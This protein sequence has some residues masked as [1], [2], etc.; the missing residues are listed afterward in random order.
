MFTLRLSL[1]KEKH[2]FHFQFKVMVKKQIPSIKLQNTWDIILQWKKMINTSH[3]FPG[4]GKRKLWTNFIFFTAPLFRAI[5]DPCPVFHPPLKT[6]H[7]SSILCLCSLQAISRLPHSL[8]EIC[9]FSWCSKPNA[10]R[11]KR[12]SLLCDCDNNNTRP[13]TQCYT[14]M[15]ELSILP[16]LFSPEKIS[17]WNVS[18]DLFQPHYTRREVNGNG[19]YSDTAVYRHGWGWF[20]EVLCVSVCVC[21][22]VCV[23]ACVCGVCAS[24]YGRVLCVCGVCE[25]VCVFVCMCVCGVCASTCESVCVCGV[26]LCIWKSG[27]CVCVVCAFCVW[28]CVCLCVYV[29]VW[30]VCLYMWEYVCVVQGGGYFSRSATQARIQSFFLKLSV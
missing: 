7:F 18:G 11:G 12:R 29:C 2:W 30:C 13:P 23:E 15:S 21:A 26:W 4:C 28:V 16:S 19:D 14:L 25:C 5:L 6:R 22:C 1:S 20:L 3:G 27:V 10:L 24:A 8:L 17:S 9:Q